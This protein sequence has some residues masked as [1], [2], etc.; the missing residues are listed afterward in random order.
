MDESC[1]GWDARDTDLWDRVMTL[2]TPAVI[3]G[4]ALVSRD[5]VLKV[6]RDMAKVRRAYWVERSEGRQ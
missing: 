6:I 1:E 2:P 3:D 4:D 5:S